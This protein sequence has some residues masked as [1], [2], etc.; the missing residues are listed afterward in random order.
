MW[1]ATPNITGT[2][3]KIRFA[4]LIIC[5]PEIDPY[6]FSLIFYKLA[7]SQNLYIAVLY[8]TE[9][10]TTSKLGQ[11][12]PPNLLWEISLHLYWDSYIVSLASRTENRT[13]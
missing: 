6:N 5:T 10:G 2:A 7:I 8:N 1:V 11:P 13:L 9:Q 12:I 3:C 4:G